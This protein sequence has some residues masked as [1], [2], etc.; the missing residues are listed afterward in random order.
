MQVILPQQR[1]GWL[2]CVGPVSEDNYFVWEA[3]IGYDAIRVKRAAKLLGRGPSGTSYEGGVF[4][5]LL[6]FPKDYPLSPPTMKF[7]CD[8]FHPNSTLA[9]PRRRSH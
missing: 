2:S 9:T 4:P 6:T 5:A 1:C 7:T 8:M 3:V